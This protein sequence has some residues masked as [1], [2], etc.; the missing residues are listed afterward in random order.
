M[1][2]DA[3]GKLER[4]RVLISQYMYVTARANTHTLARSHTH[5]HTHA[6]THARTHARARAHAHTSKAT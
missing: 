5:T 6:Q 2:Q 1:L 3:Q 4:L